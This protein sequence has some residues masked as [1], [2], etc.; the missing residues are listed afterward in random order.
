MINLL[1]VNFFI[2]SAISLFFL[3]A[4]NNEPVTQNDD[5][6]VI[7]IHSN[8]G[9][10][11]S[12]PIVDGDPD[13][14]YKYT[15]HYFVSIHLAIE[16]QNEL[17][18]NDLK[19]KDAE[20]IQEDGTRFSITPDIFLRRDCNRAS[21]FDKKVDSFDQDAG[22]STL[23]F[24]DYNTEQSIFNVDEVVSIRFRIANDTHSTEWIIIEDQMV[25]HWF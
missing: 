8:V 16:N 21:Y 15:E 1:K 2:V 10:D 23:L 22:C 3:G 5:F 7:V 4:C 11:N 18:M 13:P 20:V 12:I 14:N 19:I 9:M 25:G 6:N 17:E 24:L